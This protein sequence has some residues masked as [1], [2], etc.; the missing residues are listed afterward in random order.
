M[1]ALLL[2]STL[3]LVRCIYRVIEYLQGAGGE[4]QTHEAYLYA[5]DSGPMLLVMSILAIVHPS[6]IGSLLYGKKMVTKLFWVKGA[7]S[8]GETDDGR[9]E[10]NHR[11]FH[12]NG[13]QDAER[14]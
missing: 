7:A 11:P 8:D 6:E 14:A 13:L 2:A 5:L 12:G 3:V 4:L 9:L 10:L 1:V